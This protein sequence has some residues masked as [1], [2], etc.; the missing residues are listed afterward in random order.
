MAFLPPFPLVFFGVPLLLLLLL[1]VVGVLRVVHVSST[2][3]D[4]QTSGNVV[5]V[6]KGVDGGG[7]GGQG[8][9]LVFVPSWTGFFGTD[10]GAVL[11]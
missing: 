8:T 3:V 11:E 6:A 1:E 9:V 7:G 10:G 2:V 4:W 5:A